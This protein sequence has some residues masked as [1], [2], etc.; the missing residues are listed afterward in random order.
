MQTLALAIVLA[1]GVW[2]EAVAVLMALRPRHCL[3]LIELM[4][5][6]LQASSWRVNL[7]EQ[8]LRIVA[9]GALI[10]RAPASKLPPAFEVAGWI[11]VV[12]SILILLAPM[13][14][15]ASYGVL[16]TQRLSPLAIRLLSPLSAAAGAGLIYAAV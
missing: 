14:W 9:G 15:H 2:L 1:A 5:A 4:T 6:K 8:G 7:T 16:L 11:I 12:S 13:R 10:V 3:R